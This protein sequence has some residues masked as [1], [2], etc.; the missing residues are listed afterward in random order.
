MPMTAHDKER[1]E[2]IYPDGIPET[3][4]NMMERVQK[5]RHSHIVNGHLGGDSLALLCVIAERFPQEVPALDAVIA[6]T[7]SDEPITENNPLD[8]ILDE[9]EPK[10]ETTGPVNWFATKSGTAVIC[11]TKT[12]QVRGT[13]KSA[14]RSGSEKG[15]L[16]VV[17]PNS[18]NEFDVFH[19]NKVSIDPN[20]PAA[21]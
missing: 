9:H 3:V 14:F 15:M 7:E 16:R 6:S 13:Y 11:Q 5:I 4:N 21:E 20:Q 17:I 1:L 8:D 2:K 10:T 12:G 18:D 19:K